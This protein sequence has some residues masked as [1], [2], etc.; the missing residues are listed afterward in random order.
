M[1]IHLAFRDCEL[2][3]LWP[4]IVNRLGDCDCFLFCNT[5]LVRL[6]LCNCDSRFDWLAILT[7]FLCY[8]SNKQ[9]A[10]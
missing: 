3:C 7:R 2:L 4:A 6:A 9:C 5:I 1:L 10:L 8:D